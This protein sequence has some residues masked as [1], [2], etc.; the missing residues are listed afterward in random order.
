M[1]MGLPVGSLC[2]SEERSGLVA[3]RL[4]LSYW[5]S[6]RHPVSLEF[7]SEKAGAGKEWTSV[8]KT[9]LQVLPIALSFPGWGVGITE[10]GLQAF[11]LEKLLWA[12][13]GE[14]DQGISKWICRIQRNGA[15]LSMCLK[16][17]RILCAHPFSFC[18]FCKAQGTQ[19]EN[20]VS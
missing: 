11:P 12:K 2:G 7:T 1:E 5:K 19:W 13:A 9:L 18:Y 15:S 8:C 20:T 6:C 16:L 14:E 17:F 10:G 4:L 3:F